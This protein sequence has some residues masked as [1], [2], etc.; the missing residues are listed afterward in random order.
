[1]KKTTFHYGDL[2][3][4]K[5]DKYNQKVKPD[6]IYNLGAQSVQRLVLRLLNIL[7]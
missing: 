6:E 3:D 1:M 2:I 4:N 5:F 7:Q